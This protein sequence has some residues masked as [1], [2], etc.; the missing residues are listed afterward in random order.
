MNSRR[1]VFATLAALGSAIML[2]GCSNS[3]GVST[4][5]SSSPTRSAPTFRVITQEEFDTALLGFK[6]DTDEFNGNTTLTP[7]NLSKLFAAQPMFEKSYI[8]IFPGVSVDK[9]RPFL[10]VTSHIMAKKWWFHESIDYKSSAGLFHEDIDSSLRSDVVKD[11]GTVSEVFVFS[12]DSSEAL[13]LCQ[14]IAGDDL[15]VKVSPSL[16]SGHVF[17]VQALAPIT[18]KSLLNSCTVYLG[19]EQ[20]LTSHKIPS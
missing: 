14:V 20:G 7:S 3:I 10:L 4:A 5:P 18:V 12:T 6:V 8:S 2:A 11:D 1:Q 15:Q 17:A 16:S 13:K 9:G 19:L